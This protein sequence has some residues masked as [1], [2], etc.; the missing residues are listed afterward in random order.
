MNDQK[1]D[2]KNILL[3]LSEDGSVSA[4]EAWH[5]DG[6]KTTE[7]ATGHCEHPIDVFLTLAGFVKR[8]E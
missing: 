5:E 7:W 4:I 1:H 3:K 2:K 8:K 6:R